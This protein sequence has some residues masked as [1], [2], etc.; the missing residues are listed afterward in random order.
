MKRAFFLAVSLAAAAA[1]RPAFLPKSAESI[2]IVTI[3]TLRADHVG[4]YG[5]RAGA[6]PGIDVFAREGIL[7]ENAITPAPMTLPAHTSILSGYFPFRTGVRVN[8]TDR[9]AETIPLLA[10]QLADHGFA[11]A[12]FVSSLVLRKES[13]IGRGF[14]T[15]DDQFAANAGK[16][17]ATSSWSGAGKRRSITR[18]NGSDKGGPRGRSFSSGCISTSLTLPTSRRP[19]TAS[20]SPGESTTEKSPTTTNVVR[21][22]SRA[23]IRAP[24]SS[25]WPAIMENRSTSTERRPTE[26]SSTTRQSG[27][28]SFCGCR[29]NGSPAD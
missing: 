17:S 22:F 15:F 10:P 13:G 4:A 18:S 16:R 29:Q 25:C 19:P 21:R 1:C 14:S 7:F 8:G 20:A 27:Y 5:S 24:H 3:D 28:H 2:V 12:A 9:V 11:T 6:T 26:S 23:W